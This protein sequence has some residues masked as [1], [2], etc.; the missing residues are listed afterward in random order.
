MTPEAGA[1]DRPYMEECT[2]W[3]T[4]E[5]VLEGGPFPG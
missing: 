1:S 5:E 4:R 2:S 3:E